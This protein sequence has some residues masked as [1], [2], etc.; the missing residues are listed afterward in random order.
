MKNNKQTPLSV[1]NKVFGFKQFRGLQQDIINELVI[2]NDVLV[3]MATG[4]GKSLC[5]QIPALVRSGMAVVVSPLI[6]LMHNQVHALKQLGVK[7]EYINSSLSKRDFINNIKRMENNDIDILYV[8]P[9]RLLMDSFLELLKKTS[10]SLFAIDEAHC[11]SQW[12]HDFRAEYLQLSILSELFPDIPKVALTATADQI[13][14]NEIISQLNLNGS[15]IFASGFDR[16]NISYQI[17]EKNNTKKQL[18]DFINDNHKNDSGIVYCLSRKK[19]EET[20]KWLK[21]MGV[22]ALPYHAGLAQKDKQE[23]QLKFLHEENVVVVAT[24][25]FGMGI[26]KPNVRFVAHIDMP[27]NI[28]SYYQET[29]RAGRDGLAASAWMAYGLQDVIIH[30]QMVN[31]DKDSKIKQLE[32][33]KLDAMLGLCETSGCRRQT[34]LHY[35]GEEYK[36][37]CNNCD[38]CISPP[39]TWDATEEAQLILSA[40]YRTKQTFGVAHIIDVVTGK[41]TDKIK[42]FGHDKLKLFGQGSHTKAIQWRSI[43]RQLIAMQLVQVKMESYG[44]ITLN[45]KC[46]PFL[47][48]E[49]VLYLKKTH[50]KEKGQ[51]KIKT[52]PIVNRSIDFN[53]ELYDALKSFRYK[54]AKD[55]GVPPYIIFHDRTLMEMSTKKP[56]SISELKQLHG[57][58]E[59]KAINFGQAFIDFIKQQ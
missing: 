39:N 54:V 22:N 30:R 18:L 45:K 4:A 43:F 28:E 34:L 57:V 52:S 59:Q 10:L 19:T 11:I 20:A 1:L 49:K 27:K 26:D 24:I 8:A 5:Y 36:E 25:A 6:S 23:N 2:G 15:K 21:E 46:L 7:A 29:G 31:E 56:Q 50:I 42:R 14:R 9:E 55:I 35:F 53:S 32:Q 44:S 16:K 12:G 41:K 58:G 47:K 48:G 17:V 33:R 37:R 38:N 40:I 13:T 3:L 51:N